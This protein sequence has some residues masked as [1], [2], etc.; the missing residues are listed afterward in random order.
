M[1][2]GMGSL[3]KKLD[4]MSTQNSGFHGGCSVG[5]ADICI[6]EGH[7]YLVNAYLPLAQLGVIF[8]WFNCFVKRCSKGIDKSIYE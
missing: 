2:F 7:R 8:L 3:E 1:G 6:R 4:A 5:I